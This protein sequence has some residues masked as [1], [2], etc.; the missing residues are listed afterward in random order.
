MLG[1]RMTNKTGMAI[2]YQEEYD[3]NNMKKWGIGIQYS[4]HT[5]CLKEEH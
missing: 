4:K 1:I 5:S 2:K 3:E